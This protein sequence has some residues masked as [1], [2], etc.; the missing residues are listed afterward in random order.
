MSILDQ[1]MRIYSLY[2][3]VIT[4]KV[5][6][7]IEILDSIFFGISNKCKLYDMI[8]LTQL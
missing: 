7:N 6:V 1:N 4:D 3:S 2:E 8:S 5:L